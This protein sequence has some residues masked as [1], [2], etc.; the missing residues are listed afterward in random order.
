M[1]NPMPVHLEP[2]ETIR[3]RG[4]QAEARDSDGHVMSYHAPFKKPEDVI[5]YVRES[6]EQGLTVTIWPERNKDWWGEE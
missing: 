4:W 1:K 6:M 5:W 3:E 2:S